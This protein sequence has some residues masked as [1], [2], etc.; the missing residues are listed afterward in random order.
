MKYPFVYKV[1]CFDSDQEYYFTQSGMGMCNSFGHAAQIIESYYDK[2]LVAVKN[3]ELLEDRS[4]I[5]L[6]DDICE[7]V[8]GIEESNISCE[9]ECDSKGVPVELC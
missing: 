7:M 4:L 9:T 3:L 1:L 8:L 6:P 2:V 5:V